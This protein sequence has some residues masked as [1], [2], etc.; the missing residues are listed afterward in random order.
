METLIHFL[1]FL[2]W[3]VFEKSKIAQIYY[4]N[5]Q[6][7]G[8]NVQ[9]PKSELTP[10]RLTNFSRPTST[11][12]VDYNIIIQKLKF[13][14][15]VFQVTEVPKDQVGW[16]TPLPERITQLGDCK[17]WPRAKPQVRSPWSMETILKPQLPFPVRMMSF[18]AVRRPRP[19]F[20]Q[21]RIQTLQIQPQPLLLPIQILQNTI[22]HTTMVTTK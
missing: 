8:I 13:P 18:V 15:F 20:H 14:Y 1:S 16:S 11:S 9:S 12:P 22:I 3:K 10:R 19:L 7:A 2:Y 6:S 5:P 21:P 17:Q 4:Y